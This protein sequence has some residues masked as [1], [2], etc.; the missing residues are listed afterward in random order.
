MKYF[1][2]PP[3]GFRLT[4]VTTTVLDTVL[5]I[6]IAQK[7]KSKRFGYMS[8]RGNFHKCSEEG[9]RARYFK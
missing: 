9:R 7:F 6:Y 5:N 2:K 3:L 1:I 4:W 8:T